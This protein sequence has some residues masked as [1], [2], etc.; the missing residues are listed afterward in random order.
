MGHGACI[1]KDGQVSEVYL[2]SDDEVELISKFAPLTLSLPEDF[3]FGIFED[4]NG[5]VVI[6][7]YSEGFVG[8]PTQKE[9]V[10][11]LIKEIEVKLYDQV[12]SSQNG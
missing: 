2:L 6:L 12:L 10:M 3:K 5:R 11:E 7:K 8:L 1:I 9:N 4:E